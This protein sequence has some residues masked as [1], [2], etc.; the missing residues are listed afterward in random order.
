MDGLTGAVLHNVTVHPV[1]FCWAANNRLSILTARWVSWVGW[2]FLKP[3][4]PGPEFCIS[5]DDAAVAGEVVRRNDPLIQFYSRLFV[6]RKTV[7]DTGV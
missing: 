6:G 4:L 2:I 1:P 7:G 3:H 5:R